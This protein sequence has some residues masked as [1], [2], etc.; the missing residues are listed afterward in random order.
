[1]NSASKV[2]RRLASPAEYM[3]M[4]GANTPLLLFPMDA[5]LDAYVVV[6]KLMDPSILFTVVETDSL[7]VVVR[8]PLLLSVV[9][10]DAA[11]EIR[12]D[13]EEE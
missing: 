2:L 13:E 9:V 11:R 5:V 12:V 6:V 8:L 3:L 7:V 1:M 4:G 10:D